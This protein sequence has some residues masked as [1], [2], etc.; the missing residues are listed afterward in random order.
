MTTASPSSEAGS[1][2]APASG[3]TEAGAGIA[4][5]NPLEPL[6]KFTGLTRAVQRHGPVRPLQSYLDGLTQ[7]EMAL[8]VVDLLNLQHQHSEV[9]GVVVSHIWNN[10]VLPQKLWQHYMGGKHKFMEEIS[11]IY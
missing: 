6:I 9:L 10:Y 7:A 1:S 4:A 3:A 8:A 11:E 2:H 5:S